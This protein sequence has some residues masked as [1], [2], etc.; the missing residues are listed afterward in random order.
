MF[1]IE[2]NNALEKHVIATR[3]RRGERV[4]QVPRHMATS[5]KRDQ[6]RH[7]KEMI[8][9]QALFNKTRRELGELLGIDEARV[10]E[11]KERGLLK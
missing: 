11:A 4:W 2:V 8:Y 1:N 5:F 10:G 9:Y 7:M 3:N 6:W